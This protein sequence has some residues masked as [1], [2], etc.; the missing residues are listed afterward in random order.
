MN[1]PSSIC[2]TGSVLVQYKRIRGEQF[3]KCLKLWSQL[4][5]SSLTP[6]MQSKSQLK[7]SWTKTLDLRI[8]ILVIEINFEFTMFHIK[9]SGNMESEKKKKQKKILSSNPSKSGHIWWARRRMT[10]SNWNYCCIN[11][12]INNTMAKKREQCKTFLLR[13]EGKKKIKVYK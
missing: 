10:T 3:V 6:Y 9:T 7:S 12:I 11:Y 4:Q 13:S 5:R 2:F 8:K 1:H